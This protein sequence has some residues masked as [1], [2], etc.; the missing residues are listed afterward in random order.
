MKCYVVNDLMPLYKDGLT[1]EETSADIQAHMEE[2]SE[3]SELYK[4]MTD[5]SNDIPVSAPEQKNIDPLKKIKARNVY[6]ILLSSL[7]VALLLSGAF[8][9]V[10]WGI[11]PAESGKCHYDVEAKVRE[12]H[13]TI[14]GPDGEETEKVSMENVLTLHFKYDGRCTR[15]ETDITHTEDGIIHEMWIYPI[16]KIP[17]DNRGKHPNEY[18]FGTNIRN[19]NEILI[20]H[21]RDKTETINLY[22]LFMENVSTEE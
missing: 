21:Y 12:W 17:F 15:E 13:T 8:L 2:C 11:I 4:L 10:F 9:F 18:S 20:I 5:S 19:E 1:S 16:V 7:A 14:T 22:E 6:K 3:C